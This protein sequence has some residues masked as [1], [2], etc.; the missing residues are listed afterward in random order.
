MEDVTDYVH[1]SQPRSDA[2]LPQPSLSGGG[3]FKQQFPRPSRRVSKHVP[4]PDTNNLGGRR[5]TSR[6]AESDRQTVVG[7]PR[8]RLQLS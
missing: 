4:R 5:L 3:L 2:S 1:P 7:R 6:R 8:Q